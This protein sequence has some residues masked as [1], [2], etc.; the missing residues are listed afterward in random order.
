MRS[1]HSTATGDP[2]TSVIKQ[3]FSRTRSI[4]MKR[5]FEG[6]VTV[7]SLITLTLRLPAQKL[8]DW[9]Y[10]GHCS[11]V[12]ADGGRS[13]HTT[14]DRQP[15]RPLGAL[16]WEADLWWS[17]G[18]QEMGTPVSPQGLHQMSLMKMEKR[19]SIPPKRQTFSMCFM[20]A[21]RVPLLSSA[22]ELPS[23]S[24][25]PLDP[26]GGGVRRGPLA[27]IAGSHTIRRKVS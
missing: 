20:V 25:N 15:G 19:V 13:Y 24:G 11:K 22:V 4:Q 17:R 2:L 21:P 18:S 10:F 5:P 7:S 26:P 3:A 1:L 23:A 12:V 27:V 9:R 8:V 16:C 14:L 6:L